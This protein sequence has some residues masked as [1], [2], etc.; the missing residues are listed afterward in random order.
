MQSTLISNRDWWEVETF[1]YLLP[2]CFTVLLEKYLLYNFWHFFTQNKWTFIL[3]FGLF[4]Y[5]LSDLFSF[6]HKTDID[7]CQLGSYSCHAQAQCV[8]VPGSYNCRCLS[9]YWEDGKT[10]CKN[11]KLLGVLKCRGYL[12]HSH[13]YMRKENAFLSRLETI[14]KHNNGCLIII[15]GIKGA[16]SPFVYFLRHPQLFLFLFAP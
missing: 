3:Y 1:L 4:V 6:F 16:V 9:G 8:N 14:V 7:E 12:I 11:S 10:N 15:F 5:R 13:W 2:N